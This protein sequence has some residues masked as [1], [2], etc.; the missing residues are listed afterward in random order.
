MGGV[1]AAFVRGRNEISSCD[2][3]DRRHSDGTPIETLRNSVSCAVT[4]LRGIK[5]NAHEWQ[6]ESTAEVAEFRG[7]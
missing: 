6:A 4:F 5:T 1:V 3:G 2:V 7:G